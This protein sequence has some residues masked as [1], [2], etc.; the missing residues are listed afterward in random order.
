MKVCCQCKEKKLFSDFNRSKKRKD[1]LQTT[2]RECQKE[3]R[4]I[5]KEKIST[6]NKKWREDNKEELYKKKK[7]YRIE[8]KEAHNKRNREWASK[9]REQ[10][11]ER[12]KKYYKLNKEAIAKRRK[13]TPEKRLS[14]NVRKSIYK[15]IKRTPD[16]A[17]GGSTFDYLPYTPEQLRE[18]IEKQ[19][20]EWMTWDNWGEWHI[21]HITPQSA[22]IY[23]SLTHT[24]FQKCWDLDNLRPISAKENLAKSNKIVK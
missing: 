22:L 6:L 14:S 9:H 15:A 18:H 10:E 17:K 2:C 4:K 12:G 19:F 5:N 7:R 8:N 24:N 16:G 3:Y 21:D 23:D 1:G 11:R 13:S 20:E